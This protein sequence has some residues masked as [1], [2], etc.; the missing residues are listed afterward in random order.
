MLGIVIGIAAVITMVALGEGA[1][2]AVQERIA[3]MGT[4]V[5]TVRPGTGWFNRGR[6]DDAHMTVEDAGIVARN[7]SSVARV[8]PEMD[9]N[10]QVEFGR[11]N[12]NFRIV[13]TS[14]AYP[15]VSRDRVAMG[16]FFDGE[17]NQGRRRVAVLGAAV[18]EALGVEAL[19]LIGRQISI[20]RIAFEVVGI[21]EE[22]GSGGRFSSDNQIFVPLK[23]AQFR[24]MGTDRIESFDA[25]VAPGAS[26]EV[27]MMQIEETLRRSHRLRPGDPND[28]WIQ[29]RAEL[30]GTFQETSRTFT[31]LLA[32]I[33]VVSLLVGGI[34]I[35]NIMLVS[36]SERTG[37]I[38]LRKALGARHRDI[39]VQFL[40][41]ALVLCLAGGLL[42]ILIGAGAAEAFSR[43]AGWNMLISPEAVALA[44]AFSAAVGLFFGIWPARRAARLD[45]IDALRYE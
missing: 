28:F 7:A 24:L 17:E 34:G 18:P 39:L 2:A 29:N 13:G 43:V 27:A 11:V 23:T 5:L 44:V 22:R 32:G 16:R 26:M 33:A 38:G 8:A 9:T 42:G 1:Q 41:E 3:R 25:T 35:M 31:Y 4:D 37:E 10:F 30:L 20:R 21:M 6:R 40:T 14:E 15:A 19:E 45:P 36:V 12:G